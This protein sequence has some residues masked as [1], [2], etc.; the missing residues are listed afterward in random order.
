[1]FLWQPDICVSMNLS[2]LPRRMLLL[3]QISVSLKKLPLKGH[4]SW[5]AAECFL[6]EEKIHPGACAALPALS[7]IWGWGEG[8]KTG[9]GYRISKACSLSNCILSHADRS[10]DIKERSTQ[11]PLTSILIAWKYWLLVK[12]WG[13]KNQDRHRLS[14]DFISMALPVTPGCEILRLWFSDY[15]PWALTVHVGPDRAGKVDSAFSIYWHVVHSSGKSPHFD[16]KFFLPFLVR[17]CLE[18]LLSEQ[19]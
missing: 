3:V 14:A 1:M 15:F 10:S 17:S 18:L 19:K 7:W 11:P 6:M 16:P 12:M 13:D 8:G 2:P 4:L 9:I 5:S